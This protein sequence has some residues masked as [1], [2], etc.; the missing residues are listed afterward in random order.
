M[1]GSRPIHAVSRLATAALT[2]AYAISICICMCLCCVAKLALA[3]AKLK[4]KSAPSCCLGGKQHSPKKN[5]GCPEGCPKKQTV[6]PATREPLS[7][8]FP[9]DAGESPF[10]TV[11][12]IDASVAA[13]GGGRVCRCTSGG[14][15]AAPY[16]MLHRIN[17]HVFVI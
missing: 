7:A 2:V 17:F 12:S 11:V 9:A 13:F 14:P 1:K 3:G 4:A 16:A 6:V 10:D 15:P 5:E 8:E